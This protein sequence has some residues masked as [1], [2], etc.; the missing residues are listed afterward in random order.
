MRYQI[1]VG[2]KAGQGINKISMFIS[3]ILAK[4]GYFVFNYRDYQSLIRGGHSFNIIS[5]SDEK[6]SS[7]ETKVDFI[8]C[9]DEKTEEIH[10]HQLKKGGEILKCSDFA[11]LNLD[12]N[13]AISIKLGKM[14]GISLEEF[15]EVSKEEFPNKE[16]LIKDLYKKIKEEKKVYLENKKRK[17]EII[18]GSHAIA[19]GAFESGIDFY[20]GYPMT[21][22]TGL[23]N[24][25]SEYEINYSKP[26]VLEPES[27]IAVINMA[28]GI[29][30]SGRK[31]MIGTSGG[32]FD[33]MTEGLSFSGQSEI[34]L[35]IYLASRP[36]P[37][38]G[39]PTYTCQSDLN[40]ALFAG[41]G[42]FPRV[43]LSPADV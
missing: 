1:L 32:G 38:T 21:P 39:V 36:G 34:P 37:S 22:A 4:R 11:D 12:V 3:K 8:I 41:H 2:G 26:K 35:V 6:I 16:N 30:F 13:I 9:L 25:M 28:L 42:E 15:L 20:L 40:L 7:C 24:A 23:L 29:S 18:D 17:I 27:E 14:F 19:K 10:K 33:L 5:F 43:V 31:V